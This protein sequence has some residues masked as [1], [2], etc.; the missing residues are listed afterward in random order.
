MPSGLKKL[1]ESQLGG[2][3]RIHMDSRESRPIRVAHSPKAQRKRR[4]SPSNVLY[5]AAELKVYTSSCG[6]ISR[7]G[8]HDCHP[9]GMVVLLQSA[10]GKDFCVELNASSSERAVS[11]V[12]TGATARDLRRATLS[13][14]RRLPKR[15]SRSEL[16]ILR[17]NAMHLSTIWLHH[18]KN[19]GADI[20]VP[21]TATFAGL[22]VGRIYKLPQFE[23][24]I[25][26][27]AVDVILRWY[28][29]YERGL[30]QPA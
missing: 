2:H 7:S 6:M 5:I 23:S 11:R 10:S 20:F 22:K 12:S 8:I 1:L 15:K 26:K 4:S 27:C 30:V 3:V 9:A 18:P 25:K 28:W 29:R 14:R 24:L 13:A 16:R 19:G 17:V 21:Y